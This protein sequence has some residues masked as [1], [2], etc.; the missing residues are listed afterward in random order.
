MMDDGWMSRTV[1]HRSETQRRFVLGN[2]P[3]MT[4]YT[5]ILGMVIGLWAL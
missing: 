3:S 5:F 1:S 2:K 4:G